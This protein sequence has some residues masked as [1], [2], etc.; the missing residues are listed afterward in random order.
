MANAL[1]EK[2]RRGFTCT[3]GKPAV[4]VACV[5]QLWNSSCKVA[6]PNGYVPPPLPELPELPEQPEQPEQVLSLVAIP[7]DLLSS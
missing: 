5:A 4:M 1:I 2:E 3:F 6:T 7:N